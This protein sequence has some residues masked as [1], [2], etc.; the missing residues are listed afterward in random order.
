MKRSAKVGVAFLTLVLAAT[1]APTGALSATN[2]LVVRTLSN[3]ADLISDGDALVEVV[4]PKGVSAT[5]LKVTLGSQDI[6]SAFA[7]RPAIGGRVVG[8]VT[9]LKLGANAL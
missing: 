5:G 4:L 9:G 8:L 6:S 7:A 2:A 3:R 1:L